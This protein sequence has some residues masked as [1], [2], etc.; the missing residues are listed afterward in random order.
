MNKLID[1]IIS[2]YKSLILIYM[3]FVIGVLFGAAYVVANNEIDSLS[4]TLFHS[5]VILM[6]IGLLM[7]VLKIVIHYRKIN[8]EL[9]N[10]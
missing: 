8:M 3:G 4:D 9:E 10:E 1:K 2:W 6:I 5:F 7:L